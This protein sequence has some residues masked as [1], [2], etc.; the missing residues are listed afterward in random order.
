MMSIKEIKALL[1][2]GKFNNDHFSGKVTAENMI[3]L[4][5]WARLFDRK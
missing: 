4:A 1:D 5:V 2:E 3:K